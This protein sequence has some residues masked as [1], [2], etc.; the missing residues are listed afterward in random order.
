V[1]GCSTRSGR[2]C[3]S[4]TERRIPG[5]LR[6][7]SADGSRDE[8]L[9]RLPDVVAGLQDRWSLAVD[10]P[11]E[12]GGQC[13][14]VAP[15]QRATETNLVLKIGWPHPESE[16]EAAGLAFWDGAGAVRLIDT[17]TIGDTTALLLERCRPGV[18]LTETSA[19]DDRDVVVAALL[20]RLRREP[21]V[22][23]VFR[24]L[25]EMCEMWADGADRG[26]TGKRGLDR[27]LI[28][29]GLQL[30]RSL[31]ANADR[32]VVLFTDLHADNVLAAKR[33]PWLAI[34]PKPYVGD[35]CYDVLQHMLNVPRIH[36]DP[37]GLVVRMAELAGLDA[38]RLRLWT[39]ARCAVMAVDDPDFAEVAT[40]LAP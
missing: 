21:S 4:V 3:L 34:D 36:R 29:A 11:F 35:P 7:A 26:V 28:R 38:D 24:P 15:V 30:F 32:E 10:E 17:T 9:A 27:G 8:W 2:H 37:S 13:A 5:A 23:H 40:R 18:T 14:W 16:H 12:P 19:P 6:A 22:G 1:K 25:Q 20:Q 31:P 39:F 33:E